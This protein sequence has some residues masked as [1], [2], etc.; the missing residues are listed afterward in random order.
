MMQIGRKIFFYEWKEIHFIMNNLQ[1]ESK[2][3]HAAY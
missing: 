2:R 1:Y 3:N